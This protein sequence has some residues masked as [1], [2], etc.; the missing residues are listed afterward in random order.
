MAQ[1]NANTRRFKE[2]LH[3]VQDGDG[4]KGGSIQTEEEEAHPAGQSLYKQVTM[5]SYQRNDSVNKLGIQM[6]IRSKK[7]IEVISKKKTKL[8]SFKMIQYS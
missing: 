6:E 2:N 3:P 4:Q 7:H 5:H 8:L 1:K